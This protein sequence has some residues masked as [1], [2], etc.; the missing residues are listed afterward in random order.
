MFLLGMLSIQCKIRRNQPNDTR[1]SIDRWDRCIGHFWSISAF[2][3]T[4][5]C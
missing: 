5:F 3:A 1:Q 2:N 4:F